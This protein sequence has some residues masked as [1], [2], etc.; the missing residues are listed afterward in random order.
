VRTCLPI[1]KSRPFSPFL[2]FC[3]FYGF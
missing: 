3:N 2:F 1:P